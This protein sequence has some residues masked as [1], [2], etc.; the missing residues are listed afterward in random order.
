MASAELHTYTPGQGRANQ[1]RSKDKAK[2]NQ[3]K[4]NVNRA[5]PDVYQIET[6]LSSCVHVP[7]ASGPRGPDNSGYPELSGFSPDIS[8]YPELSGPHQDPVLI[9]PGPGII[10]T[11]SGPGPDNSGNPELSGPYQDPV[12][13]FPGTRNYQDWSRNLSGRFRV[14]GTY[15]D[16][17][18][19]PSGPV[20]IFPCVTIYFSGKNDITP[21]YLLVPLAV[22]ISTTYPLLRRGGA[23]ARAG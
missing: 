2:P 15:Q 10:R 22:S 6:L 20:L 17:I 1:S 5:K 16:A 7:E 18:R 12:L 8:G 9:F 4:P 14:P 3:L 11:P 21:Q 19:T 23:G 13:I